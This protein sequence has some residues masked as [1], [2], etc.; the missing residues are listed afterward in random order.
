VTTNNDWMAT[1]WHLQGFGRRRGKEERREEEL[2]VGALV[3]LPTLHHL[4][5]RPARTVATR[6]TKDDNSDSIVTTLITPCQWQ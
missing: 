4:M 3:S 2:K 5:M 6:A 1:L